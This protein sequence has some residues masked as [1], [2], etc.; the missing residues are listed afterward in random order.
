MGLSPV[1]GGSGFYQKSAPSGLAGVIRQV[2]VVP[3]KTDTATGIDNPPTW[4]VVYSGTI[5]TTAA[6]SKVIVIC[7]AQIGGTA[8]WSGFARL[9]RSGTPLVQGDAA[10]S[11]TQTHVNTNSASQ[12]MT[13]EY[14]LIAS[15]TPGSAA[16]HQYDLALAIEASGTWTLNRP[17]TND[18]AAPIGACATTM[19][20]I[21][22]AP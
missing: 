3:P 22:V 18:D 21:E 12:Y 14:T 5:T 17:L 16:A 6:D 1:I 4:A 2:V 19:F 15:D 8:T 13:R 11:R 20:L 7:S 10:S 9:Q